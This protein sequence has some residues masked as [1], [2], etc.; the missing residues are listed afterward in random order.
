MKPLK[1][2]MLVRL[3]FLGGLFLVYCLEAEAQ[4]SKSISQFNPASI[5]LGQSSQY[6]VTLEV[7]SSA[8]FK[9]PAPAGLE[10][11][12]LGPSQSMQS[13]FVN[14]KF[15]TLVQTSFIFRAS[16][17]AS[18][19]YKVPAFTLKLEG[20]NFRVPEATLTVLPPDGKSQVSLDEISFLKLVCPESPIY[21]GQV[22]RCALNLYVLTA[23]PDARYN[24]PTQIGDAFAKGGMNEKGV[25]SG[26][27]VNDLNYNKIAWPVSFIP[28]KSGPQ[29]IEYQMVVEIAVPR[30]NQQSRS[31]R[32]DIFDRFFNDDFFSFRNQRQQLNL[33]TREITLQISP[34]PE[35]GKPAS[36]SGAIGKFKATQNISA[37]EMNAGDPLTLTLEVEGQGNFE[38][39]QPPEMNVGQSWKTYTPKTEFTPR[40]SLNFKGSK[41]FEYV[42]IPQHEDIE[43]TPEI[44]F[45]YFDPELGTYSEISLPAVTVTVNPAPIGT[46]TFTAIAPAANGATQRPREQT[47]LP[48]KLFPGAWVASLRPVFLSP[49]FLAWQAAPLILLSGIIF[50]RKRQLRLREDFFYARNLQAEK[51]MRKWLLKAKKAASKGDAEEFFAAAQRSIQESLSRHF[52]QRADT[53]TQSEIL[54]FLESKE[55]GGELMEEVENFFQT[56]DALKFAGASTDSPSLKEREKSLSRLVTHLA[57]L[58]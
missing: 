40:D 48:M 1:I 2:N 21:V 5:T 20:E 7:K 58:K 19:T 18:G 26:E 11:V 56:A 14:G 6:M 28:L 46:A 54:S 44:E 34:L 45:S 52:K 17:K 22:A 57:N 8:R 32:N 13:T 3:L 23:F 12:F 51:A 33:T 4:K 9:P 16:V 10:L 35:E 50:V 36:F 15:K 24:Q 29:S 43:H 42:L 39:I 53:L 25:Q 49:R 30:S 47:L 38:R 55:A 31:S 27:R 41:S 37:L